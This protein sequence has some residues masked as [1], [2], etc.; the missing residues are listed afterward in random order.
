V[1]S[2]RACLPRSSAACPKGSCKSRICSNSPCLSATV[3]P[4]VPPRYRS[5]GHAR[6]SA[7]I[8]INYPVWK[9]RG[10]FQMSSERPTSTCGVQLL[11]AIEEGPDYECDS[12]TRSPSDADKFFTFLITCTVARLRVRLR[13]LGQTQM[14]DKGALTLR[15]F[16]KVVTYV[17]GSGDCLRRLGPSTVSGLAH[18][19]TSSRRGNQLHDLKS[20]QVSFCG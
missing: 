12:I 1:P 16:R 10:I 20:Y 4:P 11:P 8:L 19:K 3:L 5:H 14:G 15:I 9:S 2:L 18:L 13:E 7:P 6:L 17:A